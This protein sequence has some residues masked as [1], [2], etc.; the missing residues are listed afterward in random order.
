MNNVAQANYSAFFWTSVLIILVLLIPI[1]LAIHPAGVILGALVFL[2]TFVFP[3]Y[4]FL[5]LLSRLP[6]G[7]RTLLS[8]IFGILTLTTTYDIFCRAS[9]SGYFPYLVV[10]L[11]VGGI[12]FAAV[13]VR[14]APGSSW[15]S[16]TGW[17]SAIAGSVVALTVA[18]VF[19][20]SGRFSN[21]EFVFYGPAGQDQ[22]YH[23]SLL[24]RLVHHVP[25]DN[26]MAAGLRAPVYHYF[27][28]L[29]LAVILRVQNAFH[30]G[31]TD[32]FDLFYRC[33]PFIVYFL[34]GALAYR[35]GRELLGKTRGGVLSVLLLLGAGGLGWIFGALQTALHA[36]H[37]A[38]MRAALFSN[39]T[40]WDGVDAMFPLVHRPAHYH[41]LLICL[42]AI[43]ILLRPERSRR[44]WILAGLVLGLMAGFNFTLAATFG[45][46]AVF[47][48]IILLLKSRQ[49]EAR[50]LAWL[51]F[52]I[53]L[54]S[55]PVTGAMVL[56]GFHS[57]AV[58]FPFRGPNLEYPATVWGSLLGRMIPQALVPWAALIMLPIVAFGIKL[59][60]WGAM[61]RFDLGEERH[62]GMAV[63]FV[64]VF[65]LSFATG[66][67][68]PYRGVGG[69][70]VVFLQPTLWIL[71]LFALRP[72]DAWLGRNQGSWRPVVLWGVLGLTWVQALLAFNFCSEAAFS[73]DSARAL[74]DI[75]LQASPDDVVAFL[76]GELI[77]RPVWGHTE[78]STN[79]SI[80]AMT[81]L[82]G[83]FSPRT[84]CV[85]FA[86]SGL[87]GTNPADVLAQADRLCQQRENDVESW[88]KGD[89]TDAAFTRLVNDHVKWV[90]V[91]GDALHD[92]ST[93]TIPWRKTAQIAVY[94]LPR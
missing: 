89:I 77:E 49:N 82:D 46:A 61:A 5:T 90:V 35:A 68:F 94:R 69:I 42:A 73:Q 70:A 88:A 26:F 44:D 6:W 84:Y 72:I 66:V 48:C 71:G 51:A 92:I 16:L 91:S 17:D 2:V 32:V 47:G 13:E 67:F 56:S 8:P 9:L 80:T 62:R 54:G 18:P 57:V 87:S 76:P 58:G 53:F 21:G 14:N 15:Q 52:F 27:D 74:Q 36:A 79:Y 83:Y 34:I 85:S 81:G 37:F 33:Y 7:L 59:F 3:G 40:S 93:S 1:V 65:C 19:W 10:A 30:L 63:V 20:R 22:L 29:T 31:A 39:W 75:R 43:N 24:Q 23:V 38:A 86:V 64:I 60:G 28:D 12:F 50:D 78:I 4:L 25:P 45:I 11:S 41:S 55:L